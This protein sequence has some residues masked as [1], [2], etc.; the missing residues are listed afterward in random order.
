MSSQCCSPLIN[1]GG[2]W[3]IFSALFGWQNSAT[4]GSIVSY[5]LYWVVIIIAFLAM[6][7]N[8]KK[9]HWPLLKAKQPKRERENSDFSSGDDSEVTHP[10]KALARD[11]T[12][13]EV[14]STKS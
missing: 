8:E 7:Y 1:G 14:R 5:N 2:G 10:E 12:V 9:G 13:S 4:V 3:G 6:R 11:A